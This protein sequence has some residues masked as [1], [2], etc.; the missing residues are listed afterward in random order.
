MDSNLFQK[1]GDF[2]VLLTRLVIR[3]LRTDGTLPVL[4][5][6]AAIW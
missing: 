6:L 5:Q 4:K 2:S 3:T 1:H